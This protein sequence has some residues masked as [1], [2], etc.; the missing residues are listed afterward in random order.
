M[1]I[2]ELKIGIIL[3]GGSIQ[4][5]RNISQIALSSPTFRPGLVVLDK[6]GGLADFIIIVLKYLVE[7]VCPKMPDFEYSTYLVLFGKRYFEMIAKLKEL[8]EDRSRFWTFTKERNFIISKIWQLTL[9]YL[10]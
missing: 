5:A 6:S 3:N 7:R 9:S 1:V 8:T 4:D 10:N 2:S